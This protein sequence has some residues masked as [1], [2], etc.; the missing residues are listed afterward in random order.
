M[1]LFTYIIR[2]PNNIMSRQIKS[3]FRLVSQI[4]NK[5]IIFQYYSCCIQ[6]DNCTFSR[7][8]IKCF[9]SSSVLPISSCGNTEDVSLTSVFLS[10]SFIPSD[11]RE[12]LKYPEIIPDVFSRARNMCLFDSLCRHTDA[13][14]HSFFLIKQAIKCI[15]ISQLQ[16]SPCLNNVPLL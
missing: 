6:G 3:T 5:Y 15:A 7:C 11:V 9:M 12:R 14:G 2:N 10:L 16:D 1:T 4:Y 8:G 13:E